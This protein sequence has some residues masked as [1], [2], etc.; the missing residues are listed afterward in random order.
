MMTSMTRIVLFMIAATLCAGFLLG[1]V[2]MPDFKEVTMMVF[3]AFFAIKGNDNRND[4][5]ST[6]D[7][8]N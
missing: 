5:G 6:K 8:E 7:L 2:P 1:K 4:N 3:V